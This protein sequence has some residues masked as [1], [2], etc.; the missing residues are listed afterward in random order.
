MYCSIRDR[1]ICST[2]R[3]HSRSYLFTPRISLYTVNT[4]SR[5]TLWF[6]VLPIASEK[7]AARVL[8]W[9]LTGPHLQRSYATSRHAVPIGCTRTLP[10]SPRLRCR[11]PSRMAGIKLQIT[12]SSG[13]LNLWHEQSRPALKSD[14]ASRVGRAF[15]RTTSKNFVD[16]EKSSD[17]PQ[18]ILPQRKEP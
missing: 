12:S 3:I 15:Y 2:S 1:C 7:S 18:A 10:E 14:L 5:S 17:L 11:L 4:T 9:R 6:E 16:L 8:I 13:R